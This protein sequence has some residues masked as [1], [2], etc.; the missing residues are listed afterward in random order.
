V[1][2]VLPSNLLLRGGLQRGLRV[3]LPSPSN[4][5]AFSPPLNRL[6]RRGPNPDAYAAGRQD[7]IKGEAAPNGIYWYTN[8]Y[9]R[10]QPFTSICGGGRPSGAD[11]AAV[12]PLFPDNTL[13]ADG[14]QRLSFVSGMRVYSKG[15]VVLRVEFNT[16]LWDVGRVPVPTLAPMVFYTPVAGGKSMVA[17]GRSAASLP[18]RVRVTRFKP[19][20]SQQV[21]GTAGGTCSVGSGGAAIRA[22]AGACFTYPSPYSNAKFVV[23]NGVNPNLNTSSFYTSY[24]C[25]GAANPSTPVDADR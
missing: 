8:N 25:P 10:A 15:D 4:S 18:A 13:L 9:C 1:V 12:T 6:G 3:S 22:G 16:Q 23:P 24:Y 7:Y 11:V 21:L 5:A 19:S 14:T 20:D 2:H 17:C